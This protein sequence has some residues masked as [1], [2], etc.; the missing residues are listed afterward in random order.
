ML[1]EE[2]GDKPAVKS[3][4]AKRAALRNPSISFS[5]V[6][7]CSCWFWSGATLNACLPEPVTPGPLMRSSTRLLMIAR[8]R[9]VG[10]GFFGFCRGLLYDFQGFNEC[11]GVLFIQR[12]YHCFILRM[13]V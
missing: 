10:F 6:I 13:L 9:P 11:L 5:C 12:T 1:N 3:V 2:E 8:P 7:D 4:P